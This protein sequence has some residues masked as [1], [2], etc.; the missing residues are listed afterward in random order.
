LSVNEK[1]REMKPEEEELII[2]GQILKDLEND[3]LTGD[4]FLSQIKKELYL[5]ENRYNEIVGLQ[6]SKLERLKSDL[7]S[8]IDT[9]AEKE[10]SIRSFSPG[11]FSPEKMQE[12][13]EE[14]I[15]PSSA[16]NGSQSLAAKNLFRQVAKAIHPDLSNDENDRVIREELMKRAN[17]AFLNNDVDRL[18]QIMNEWENIPEQIR[19]NDPGSSLIRTIRKIAQIKERIQKIDEEKMSIVRSDIYRFYQKDL[20]M[21]NNG[22]DLLQAI[23]IEVNKNI[24]EILRGI[25]TLIEQ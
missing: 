19:G 6:Y 2:K 7:R 11:K 8:I 13:Y 20:K 17:I 14:D 10:N 4:F 15:A 1:L 18:L 9:Y 16:P 21:R 23:S 22:G 12:H 3:L 25:Q 5:F 24:E